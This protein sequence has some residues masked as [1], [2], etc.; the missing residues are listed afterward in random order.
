MVFVRCK[1]SE[2]LSEIAHLSYIYKF[3]VDK[4]NRKDV[5][6]KSPVAIIPDKQLQKLRFVVGNSDD[7]V[8]IEQAPLHLGDKITVLRGKLQGL[9]GNIEE[10]R[11][12]STFIVI[13]IDSLGCAKVKIN[14]ID[15]ERIR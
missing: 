3:L 5:S 10:F 7:P 1:E 15:V 14:P 12:G 8:T 9:E 6:S 13:R 2:R 11:D 4:A